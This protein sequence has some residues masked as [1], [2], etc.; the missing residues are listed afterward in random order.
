MENKKSSFGKDEAR[1]DHTEHDY[2]HLKSRVSE[3]Y[4]TV[5]SEVARGAKTLKERT[6]DSVKHLQNHPHDHKIKW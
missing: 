1:H 4:R 3:D 5:K 6:D 2:G